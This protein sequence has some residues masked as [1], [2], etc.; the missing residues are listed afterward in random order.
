MS[1]KRQ[2]Q[3]LAARRK[4]DIQ[5]GFKGPLSGLMPM[6]WSDP[7]RTFGGLIKRPSV[8]DPGARSQCPR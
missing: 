8:S 2:E 6:S 7:K 4:H 3:T 5:V 1:L